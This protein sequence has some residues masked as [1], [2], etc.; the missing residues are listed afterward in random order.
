MSSRGGNNYED[1]FIDN[2]DFSFKKKKE[3]ILVDEERMGDLLE[4]MQIAGVFDRPEIDDFSDIYTEEELKSNKADVER[5]EFE[6]KKRETPEGKNLKLISDLFE[7]VIVAEAE[8]S[9]WAG[10]NAI[11]H[12]ASL[13]DDYI[14]GV[15][16][17]VEFNDEKEENKFLALGIDVTFGSYIKTEVGKKLKRIEK[18]IREGKLS[19]VKYFSDSYGK[20]QKLE[21]PKVVAGASGET[22]RQLL[23]LYDKG[24]RK[25]LASH[26]YQCALLVS[27][28]QQAVYFYNIANSCGNEIAADKYA[29]A[30]DT[31]NEIIE[32]RLELLNSL[33][34]EA[35]KDEV[36]QKIME[37]VDPK[38]D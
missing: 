3:N 12:S 23:E 20:H 24:D 13:Y 10:S 30:V 17:I 2:I 32:P 7:G 26:P 29:E 25:G 31:L 9:E 4:R 34:E 16:A 18:E 6:F 35:F 15:D 37:I 11:V 36:I 28:R 19:T 22:V 5:L 33:Y 38:E 1:S 27:I 21:L 14:N 8:Q